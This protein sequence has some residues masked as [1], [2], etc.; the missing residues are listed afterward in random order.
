MGLQIKARMAGLPTLAYRLAPVYHTGAPSRCQRSSK[1]ASS[2]AVDKIH[3]E[4]ETINS[5][6]DYDTLLTPS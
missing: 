2:R 3:T 4:L 1:S 6:D 5:F